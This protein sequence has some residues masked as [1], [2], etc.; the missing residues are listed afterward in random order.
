ML[1]VCLNVTERRNVCQLQSFFPSSYKCCRCAYYQTHT[2]EILNRFR[3][4]SGV[5]ALHSP[6]V[7]HLFNVAITCFIKTG[8]PP[9]VTAVMWHY[10]HRNVCSLK[11]RRTH[12]MQTVQ[13]RWHR[14][15][16]VFL[17]SC[18]MCTSNPDHFKIAFQNISPCIFR[19]RE[20]VTM[21]DFPGGFCRS[22]LSA[23]T[24]SEH[25]SY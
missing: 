17:T 12:C 19:Y 23:V 3:K 7:V 21:R 2:S 22:S 6:C 18:Y 10:L 14:C 20:H 25:C 15:G 11:L 4:P 16:P 13:R 24:S 8:N 9:N 5:P 1:L